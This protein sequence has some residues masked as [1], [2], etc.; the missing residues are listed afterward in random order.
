MYAVAPYSPM[1]NI[2]GTHRTVVVMLKPAATQSGS[3]HARKVNSSSSGA[4]RRASAH[5]GV[6]KRHTLH[7]ERCPRTSSPSWLTHHEHRAHIYQ[8]VTPRQKGHARERVLPVRLCDG[9]EEQAC[10]Q[11]QRQ[12]G[13]CQH[14]IV[15]HPD[16][17]EILGASLR[18][19]FLSAS[20]HSPST[21]TVPGTYTRLAPIRNHY[22]AYR[23]GTTCAS[24]APLHLTHGSTATPHSG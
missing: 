9:P 5:Q 14:P 23:R 22:Q 13:C 18:F 24:H 15:R 8:P 2:S 20:T 7:R 10:G 17:R 16:Q 4:W 6:T 11:H 21:A 19:T 3:M 12:R 1:P